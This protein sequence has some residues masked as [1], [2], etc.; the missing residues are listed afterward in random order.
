MYLTGIYSVAEVSFT[1]Q[2]LK[3]LHCLISQPTV[4]IVKLPSIVWLNKLLANLISN[5]MENRLRKKKQINKQTTR[6][7]SPASFVKQSAITQ[8]YTFFKFEEKLNEN[9][10]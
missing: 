5:E 4:E 7:K 2:K 1:C 8:I 6:I 9:I 10:I 3:I